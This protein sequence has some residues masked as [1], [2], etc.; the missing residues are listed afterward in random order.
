[1]GAGGKSA[2]PGPESSRFVALSTLLGATQS[3][4]PAATHA[5]DTLTLV[6]LSPTTIC[7]V[8]ESF[9]EMLLV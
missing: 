6:S 3:S 1:M 5:L 2:S 4:C 9:G 7:Q 8:T